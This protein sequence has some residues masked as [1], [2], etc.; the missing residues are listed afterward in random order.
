MKWSAWL[1]LVLLSGCFG[2]PDDDGQGDGPDD[3]APDDSGAAS[4]ER[5]TWVVGEW[6]RFAFDDGTAVRWIVTSAQ[7]DYTTDVD[8][9]DFAFADALEDI[10][11]I[12][13]ISA[14]LD[15]QQ[16]GTAVKFFD[17]PLTDGKTWSLTWD[18]M[19]FDANASVDGEQATIT[20]TSGDIERSYG[21]DN[22]T[23]WFTHIESR[24]NGSLEWRVEQTGHGFDYA[25]T[26][27]RY[28]LHGSDNANLDGGTRN[29]A[30]TL[31]VPA[32]A[33]DLW[34]ALALS[35]T[36]GQI[37]YSLVPPD[38]QVEGMT[39][40]SACPVSLEGTG[41]LVA[42]EGTWRSV[43]A[44]TGVTGSITVVARTLEE[45]RL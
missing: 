43:L 40:S 20:A 12:G 30:G 25:D 36:D 18:G 26:Y 5:P 15:G 4:I 1:V 6:W 17:W 39:V 41:T 14:D 11:T 42:A 37:Q 9:A 29:T 21:Y 7:G 33:T 32:E 35:C 28:T 22:E 34:Y 24:S 8:N 31:A 3:P 10:S 44:A 23:Q 16:D 19:T 45:Y 2:S 13:A 27:V 38:P